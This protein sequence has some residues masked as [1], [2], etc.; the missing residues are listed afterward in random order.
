MQQP[1]GQAAEP[2]AGRPTPIDRESRFDI[3]ELFFSTTNPAGVITSGNDV[4]T[5]VS[6]YRAEELIGSPH[7]LIR[8]PDMPRCIFG[9]L[10]QTIQAGEPI[11]AYVKNLARDG[12]YYWVLALVCPIR[13][14]YL[15][16]RMKPGSGLFHTVRGLYQQLLDVEKP[17]EACGEGRKAAM[18]ASM[19]LLHQSLGRLGYQSYAHLMSQMLLAELQHRDD[20]LATKPPK[21]SDAI[22]GEMESACERL[23][24]G[25]NRFF[26][27]LGVFGDL[28]R[29]LLE[30]LDFV[31]GLGREL[32][33]LALNAQLAAAALGDDGVTLR[34]VSQQMSEAA[35]Q[36]A[37]AA[38]E[39]AGSMEQAVSQLR[40][41]SFA[42]GSSR[43]SVEMMASFVAELGRRESDP[44][45][46]G[47]VGS[48]AE[49]VS[50]NL[51]TAAAVS[52][53]AANQIHQLQ[54]CI[55]GFVKQ[56]RTLEVLHISGRVEAVRC[57]SGAQVQNV[58]GQLLGKTQQTR[59]KLTAL[60][61]LTADLP[62]LRI[63]HSSLAAALQQLAA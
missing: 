9:L 40:G 36:I 55:E 23:S 14:G 11:A 13:G 5:R 56:V 28:G 15:S 61:D 54:F 30:Q 42:I 33:L 52:Q 25:V 18:K 32:G 29:A 24:V 45:S 62:P 58:F 7:N 37:T 44:T 63:D 51:Q 21:H 12:S 2:S 31:R 6:G 16:I 34:V 17:I 4:F 3:N 47:Q 8:H 46:K 10:W 19:E 43:L 26:S 53:K 1:Q 41:A 60:I 49:T 20:A 22:N 57:H 50:S 35:G 39:L 48:L 27:Q 38:G 59:Q